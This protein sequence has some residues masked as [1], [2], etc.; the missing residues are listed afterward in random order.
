ML[1]LSIAPIAILEWTGLTGNLSAGFTEEIAK[2]IALILLAGS[3]RKYP[4][5]LN[6]LL[7][8]AAV[9]FGF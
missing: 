5:I 9:E 1:C 3:K 7:L 4:Y 6:G 2:I 8:G